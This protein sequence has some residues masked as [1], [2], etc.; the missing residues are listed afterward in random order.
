M[1]P[2]QKV[3]Y[4]AT[5]LDEATIFKNGSTTYYWSSKFFPR[6]VRD[7]VFKL[8]SFVRVADDYVDQVPAQIEEFVAL[9]KG[10]ERAKADQNFNTVRRPKD[11]LNERVIKNIVDVV[12]NYSCDPAWID[13]F[14][15]SM[16]AD[17]DKKLCQTLDDTLD[18]VYGS[19]EVI[20]LLMAKVLGLPDEAL[21]YAKLQGRAMQMINFIR[22]IDEDNCLG[23]MY[24]PQVDLKRFKLVDLRR[25]NNPVQLQAFNECIRF[26]IE[27]YREWQ[28]EADKGMQYI[29]LRLRTPLE[30]AVAMYNWTAKQIESRPE[31]VFEGSLKPSKLRV[32]STGTK[33]FLGL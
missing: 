1:T 21:P 10:W 7:D 17:V 30:T 29:P 18:Y 3:R 23:R 5:M 11:G 27:R 25:P 4:T 13:A 20:G 32:I 15:E 16:Q 28:T 8:Y 26:E 22:D 2:W 24:L 6:E 31:L 19:A 33:L 9:R 14:L 12:R